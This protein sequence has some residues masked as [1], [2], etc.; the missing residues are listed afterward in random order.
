M[1][2]TYTNGLGLE[3]IPTGEQAGSW[4]ATLN[5][6]I[7]FLDQAIGGYSAI[8]LTTSTYALEITDGTAGVQRSKVIRFYGTPGAGVAVTIVPN[9]A[10]RFLLI[11][12]DS[13]QIVTIGQGSGATVA[14]AAGKSTLIFC[15]GAGV[16]AAV[17]NAL[18][19]LSLATL[20]AS[21]NVTVGGTVVA[22][23]TVSGGAPTDSGHLTTKTY[24]DT[25][26]GGYA[27]LTGS[28][29][30]PS[31]ITALANSKI[32]GL[33]ASA[34]TDTTNA[35]NISAGALSLARIAQGGAVSG[36]ALGWNGSAWA[37][38]AL[39]AS[40]TT[41]ATNASNLA[42]G[43]LALARLAQG[44]AT[45]GQVLK[46]DGS[47]W[48]PS[49]DLTGDGLGEASVAWGNITGT[50]SAQS[51]VYSAITAKADSSHTHALGTILISDVTSLQATLDGKAAASHTQAISTI[52]GLQTALDAKAASSHTHT[53]SDI[54]GTLSLTKIAQGGATTGQYLKW[55]G[56]AWVP[57]TVT[58]SVAWGGI[59]GT[60]SAQT[61][62]A[63]LLN[64]KAALSHT[65]ASTSVYHGGTLLSTLMTATM[66]HG[67]TINYNTITLTISGIPVNV[68][69]YIYPTTTGPSGF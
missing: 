8:E 61:D 44:G 46:W 50:L 30:N 56:S 19:N 55:S 20:T 10:E 5:E 9:N 29:S 26:V 31:W 40:A 53:E 16:G 51:D 42:T 24:V 2:S 12:N 7:E 45:M 32:T 39:A 17:A 15:D 28:Y 68:V 11:V 33:V 41:D 59:T 23:G 57:A 47:A 37:P 34:T 58:A 43:A 60:V 1:P 67:H 64:D 69:S 66:G 13:D 36:N 49:T 65:H 62:L 14:I 3:L 48:A 6:T 22:T 63:N 54:T 27:S 25:L 52:T 18:A 21:G 4:G 35:D 38:L